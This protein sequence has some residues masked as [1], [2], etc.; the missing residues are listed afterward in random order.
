MF[1]R[2]TRDRSGSSLV[3]AEVLTKSQ[4]FYSHKRFLGITALFCSAIAAHTQQSV[5]LAWD[6]NTE[7]NVAGYRLYYGTVTRVYTSVVNAGDATTASVGNLMPGV[8]YRFAV[9]ALNTLGFESDYSSEIAFTTT[10]VV[11]P[12]NI[13]PTLAGLA[14]LTINEDSGAQTVL[15]TG[16]SSGG[17]NQ[18]LTV[19]ASATPQSLIP[20]VQTVYVSPRT[21]G[22]VS[23]VTAPNSWGTGVVNVTVSDG[24]AQVVRSFA[25]TVNPA[26]DA[27]TI[28]NIA[29]RTINQNTAT[30]P[31]GFIIGD[32]DTAASSLSLTATSSNP[33]L[34][35]IQN[36]VFGGSGTSRTV[37][38][39]PA[40]DQTGTATINITVSDGFQTAS[41]SW[42]LTVDSTST[43]NTP[44]ALSGVRSTTIFSGGFSLPIRFSVSDAETPSDALQVWTV[45]SNPTLIPSNNILFQGSGS[46][47]TLMVAANYGVGNATIT[48]SVDDGSGNTRSTNFGV[49]VL[50]RPAQMVYLPFEAEEGSIVAPMQLYT[51][52][53]ATY[54]ATTSSGQGTV[55]LQFSITQPGNYIIWARHLS[56]NNAQDSFFVSVDGVEIPYATAIGTWS[57]DWQW[58]RVTVPDS[59]STQDPRVLS[60]SAGPHTVTFRGNEANCGLDRIIIC[61]DLEFVPGVDGN[62]APGISSFSARTI[63]EDTS[64]GPITFTVSDA[65]TPGSLVINTASSNPSLVPT[66]SITIGGTGTDRTLTV[67]P[68]L[69]QSGTATITVSVS[70]GQLS[71]SSSFVLT[72]NAVN[73]TPTIAALPAATVPLNILTALQPVVIADVDTAASSLVVTGTSSDTNVLPNANIVI[74]TFGL[75][76]T[77][78]VHPLQAGM[79]TVT[80]RVSDGLAQSAQSFLLTVTNIV[81]T[82]APPTLDPIANVTVTEDSGLRVVSLTGISAGASENQALGVSVSATPSWLIPTPQVSYTSPSATGAVSFAPGTNMSGSGTVTV[83]V[84]DGV[85][86]TAR[87]FSVTVNPVNDPPGLTSLGSRRISEN[88][89]TGP[90]GFT[91]GD[92]ETPAAS[93]ALSG[94][95]SNPT[96]VPQGNIMFGGSSSN[97]TVQVTPATG[98]LGTAMITVWVSDGALAGSR[99]FELTVAETNDAPVMAP[100][101]NATVTV[102]TAS[103]LSPVEIGD[104]DSTNLVVT[105]R[106]S[107][108]SVLPDAN[109]LI[110]TSGLSR[111]LSVRPQRVGTTTVTLTVSDGYA[112]SSQSFLLSVTNRFKLRPSDL[113]TS[114]SGAFTILWES[115]L[116]YTYRVMAN[117]DLSYTNWVDVSGNITAIGETTAWT[118]HAAA[119][120][121]TCFYLIEIVP[122]E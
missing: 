50:A 122:P 57:P 46:D 63:A 54:V 51:D 19:T 13:P 1:T 88:T 113:S 79:A 76:R 82:N 32:V 97:R 94:T 16:I 44:P 14:N 15:L 10:N 112:Q 114:S 110:G 73:D 59:A 60:L 48:L 56:P 119:T 93:L 61:N 33:S 85:T 89:T 24:L 52:S 78:S 12:P 95:S 117:S 121:R 34:V 106:S 98:Q 72:V 81:T 2:S 68:A 71:A 100:L 30:G 64:T 87:T 41:D 45:S 90:I 49:N 20:S 69:N 107:N 65:E 40:T 3:E 96:L 8:T 42:L 53:S 25:V 31:I 67:T 77:L 47:G 43:T 29:D 36:I 17:E 6:R 58:T 35:P 75:S 39:T 4:K 116:G 92:A 80:V 120:R 86:A 111:T 38:V 11:T 28:A 62:T 27:P 23:F 66:A 101:A 105:G 9:T 118:D 83:T 104:V 7:A 84:S 74:G 109:I 26:N 115:T 70:D 5:T 108:T 18:A 91:I 55:S 99:T 21:T 103:T 102:K 22:T 37:N